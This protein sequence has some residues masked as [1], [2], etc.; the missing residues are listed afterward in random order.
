MLREV[1]RLLGVDLDHKLAEI[2]AQIEEFRIKTT[3]QITAQLKVTS[4]MV[5]CVLVGTITAIATFII[6]LVALYRWVEMYKGPFA[7]LAAVGGI[8]AL[9]TAV[10]FGLAFGQ[11]S[12]RPP[13]AVVDRRQTGL[14]PR[15]PPPPQ[16][17]PVALSAL[18][19]S[20]PPNASIFDVLTHRFSTRVAGAGDEAVDAAVSIM[21]TGSRSALFGTL[22]VA[23][24]VGVLLGRRR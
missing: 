6:V 17:A 18:L 8:M 15:P 23:A 3:R 1:L 11:R 7:A 4:L 9:L 20:P 22:A 24:L 14:P 13:S 5:A 16:P 19:P 12:R 21:R 2:R 10:M